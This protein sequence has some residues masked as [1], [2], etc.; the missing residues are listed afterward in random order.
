MGTI[1]I[2]KIELEERDDIISEYKRKIG[3][4]DEAQPRIPAEVH[5]EYG[6]EIQQKDSARIDIL[7]R[8]AISDGITD[9]QEQF[10]YAAQS[11]SKENEQVEEDE[12]LARAEWEKILMPKVGSGFT[13]K[14][15]SA[16]IKKYKRELDVKLWLLQKPLNDSSNLTSVPSD[17]KLI[18]SY[19]KVREEINEIEEKNV[20]RK[21]NKIKL[22]EEG[23]SPTKFGRCCYL[24]RYG[25]Q[26]D[27]KKFMRCVKFNSKKWVRAQC[28]HFDL[29]TIK[30]YRDFLTDQEN[31]F[32]DRKVSTNSGLRKK[33]YKKRTIK[34]GDNNPF[35]GRICFT[36]IHMGKTHSRDRINCQMREDKGVDK[37]VF[38]V[39]TYAVCESYEFT[40][41]Q[42]R[43][44]KY[45]SPMK[46]SGAVAGWKRS[47]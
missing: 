43:T 46:A 38:M 47:Q 30:A 40:D 28:R 5:P 17:E 11:Y 19:F 32:L 44:V 37:K 13:Q 10:Q 3:V 35:L 12:K 14:E 1:K 33:Y 41:N 16:L 20:P 34:K 31:K 29:K 39:W 22:T 42:A 21:S 7:K 45:H 15:R 2:G 24:C 9:D 6:W 18:D 27:D 8:K 25:E 4:G 23:F 26:T 36:C